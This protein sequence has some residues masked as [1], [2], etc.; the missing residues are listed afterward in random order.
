MPPGFLSSLSSLILRLSTC[1]A[2]RAASSVS[3]LECL[4][5]DSLGESGAEAGAEATGGRGGT[6]S[7]RVRWDRGRGSSL[8]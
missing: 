4:G 8:D 7:S 5:L 6:A 1:L 3:V 2:L